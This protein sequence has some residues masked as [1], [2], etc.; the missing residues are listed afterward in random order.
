MSLTTHDIVAAGLEILDNYGL[1]DLSM[2]RLAQL[3]DVKASALYWHVANKQTLLGAVA[4]A[5][6]ARR[7]TRDTTDLKLPW[8][9]VVRQC[10]RDLHAAVTA[11]PDGA[12]IVMSMWAFGMG[13]RAPFDE[14]REILGATGLDARGAKTAARTLLHFV[15]GH[16]YDE[17]SHAQAARSGIA[18]DARPES[19]FDTGLDIIL[20]GVESLVVR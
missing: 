10:C 17:Q 18:S 7:P 3:L 15:Y 20:T 14:L 9:E 16:A 1:E 2:R 19:D 5:I 11:Y 4:D 12:D 8:Q 13:G 6:L